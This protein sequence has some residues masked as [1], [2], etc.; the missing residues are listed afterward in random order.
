MWIFGFEEVEEGKPSSQPVDKPS[1]LS[2]LT[3][4][5]TFADAWGPV[6]GLWAGTKLP[7]DVFQRYDLSRGCIYPVPNSSKSPV[8]G[9]DAVMCHWDQ[10]MLTDR[11][12][13]PHNKIYLK[14]NDMLL[15]G[16]SLWYNHRCGYR[17]S[18]YDYDYGHGL[19]A[20]GTARPEWRPETWTVGV[21]A[22]QYVTVNANVARKKY[23]GTTLK[24]NIWSKFK[25][26]PKDANI[27]YLNHFLGVE[28]SYCS[29]NARRVRLK[30]LFHIQRVKDRLNAYKPD[31]ETTNWGQLFSK[32]LAADNFATMRT[33]WNNQDIPE[34]RENIADL[35]CKLLWDLNHTGERDPHFVAAYYNRPQPEKQIELQIQRNTWGKC[36]RDSTLVA[37]YAVVGDNCLKYSS[38]GH[39]GTPTSCR[40]EIPAARTV[41]ETVISCRGWPLA[42]NDC[43]KIGEF[44]AL[45]KVTRVQMD[46]RGRCQIIL[47]P[48]NATGMLHAKSATELSRKVGRGRDRIY[49]AIIRAQM[50]SYG[51][52]EEPR[53]MQGPRQRQDEKTEDPDPG[54][55]GCCSCQ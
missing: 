30:D 49:W 40:S 42:E 10:Y 52:M 35:I 28:I 34:I 25:H 17:L 20:L 1:K 18:H 47:A 43:V 37:T 15:I 54:C 4:I 19:A 16:A 26:D 22:G 8:D 38:T 32:A 21:T 24:E 13:P 36:L 12:Q 29:G 3:R 50:Q 2:I 33:L 44:E 31:W 27:E 11:E 9:I 48:T 14:R 23:P 53:H 55:C 41:L 51:G 39:L 46:T 5:D 7:N 45:F 6:W